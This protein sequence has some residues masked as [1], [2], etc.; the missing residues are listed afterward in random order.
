M[1]TAER[2]DEDV[3]WLDLDGTANSRDLAGL[4]TADGRSVRPH[5]LIRSDNLQNLSD[6][7]VRTLVDDIGVRAVADLRT[8]VEVANEGDGPLLANEAVDVVHLSLFPESGKHTDVAAAD[9]P[10]VLPWQDR[11]VRTDG[12]KRQGASAVYL[13]YLDDRADSVLAALRLIAYSPGATV[14]HCAAGKDRTGTIVALAL[15]EAGVTR[16][17]IVAD[18][19]RSGER[20]EAIFARLR[21][22]RTYV[23]DLAGEDADKHRPKALTMERLLEAIDEEFGGVAAWLRSHGWTEQ[24][25]AALR[26]KLLD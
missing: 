11:E 26:H 12:A 20:M 16:E 7:D 18:Y 23:D 17:A 2:T 13:G 21:S 14:V 25:A 3:A 1:G 8:G 6:R 15:T 10:V 9:G 5:R 24:D 22:T 4:P 19:V